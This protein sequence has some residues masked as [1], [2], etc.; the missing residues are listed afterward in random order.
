M[1][2][3][4]GLLPEYWHWLA[5]VVYSTALLYTAIK[6]PWQRIKTTA[7][8][9]HA[10][11]GSCV[12]LL[13]LWSIK[14]D[15]IPGLEYHYLGAT[16]LT[17]MFG[18]QLAFIGLSIVL[19]GLVF[20][21]GS[22]WQSYPLNALVMGLFPCLGSYLVYRLVDR[23][24]PNHFFIYIFV[25]AFFGAALVL[26][27]LLA[28][29]MLIMMA[30]EIYTWEELSSRYLPFV[31]LMLFPEAFITGFLITIMVVM[32]PEWVYTFDDHRYLDGK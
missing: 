10:Y 11:F 25:N 29:A 9:T 7:T 20:N 5:L 17:L 30:G 15:V 28:L 26:V 22:D 24:L 4:Y 8:T 1:N 32:R 2:F 6:C 31:P 21:G 23:Y 16:L 12:A 14:S 18:W 13:L 3:P 27:S 19:L